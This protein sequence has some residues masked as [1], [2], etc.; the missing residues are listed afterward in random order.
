MFL[1]A[2]TTVLL[3]LGFRMSSFPQPFQVTGALCSCLLGIVC[4]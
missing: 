1:D 4:H 2:D 3:P